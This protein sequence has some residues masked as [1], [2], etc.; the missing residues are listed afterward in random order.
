MAIPV[1]ESITAFGGN[2][3]AEATWTLTYPATVNNNDLIILMVANDGTGDSPVFNNTNGNFLTN[4]LHAESFGGHGGGTSYHFCDGTETGNITVA[5]ST[6]SEEWGG[7]VIRI[8]GADTGQA[9]EIGT[10]ATG[11]GNDTVGCS[12]T[13][14]GW[15][16]A[17]E[18]NLW[19]WFFCGDGDTTTVDTFPTEFPDNQTN[20]TQT[21]TD[22]ACA[23]ATDDTQTSTQSASAG[24]NNLSTFNPFA[25]WIVGV[26]GG[27]AGTVIQVPM[28]PLR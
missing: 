19:F 26:K 13:P 1:I 6:G 21:G 22:P 7:F 24:S 28:G 25:E 18:D 23:V 9:P 20:N 8:S 12:L 10:R 17:N 14:S 2:G 16:G 5:C 4:Q 27:T 3:T 11:N 15:T